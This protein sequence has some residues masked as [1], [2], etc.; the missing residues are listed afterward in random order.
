M[1]AKN[2]NMV[3]LYEDKKQRIERALMLGTSSTE[4]MQFEQMLNIVDERLYELYE[5]MGKQ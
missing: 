4:T 2:G 1:F 5:I 3:S